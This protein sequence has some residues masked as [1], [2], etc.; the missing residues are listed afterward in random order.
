[1]SYCNP[2]VL[3]SKVHELF[4]IVRCWNRCSVWV[5]CTIRLKFG[6]PLCSSLSICMQI[7]LGDCVAASCA[8]DDALRR[9]CTSRWLNAAWDFQLKVIA[10]CWG[11]LCIDTVPVELPLMRT[12]RSIPID[13]VFEGVRFDVDSVSIFVIHAT[14]SM[15]KCHLRQLFA[16]LS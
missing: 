2:C 9:V 6:L 7:A 5:T 10:R 11:L 1:M 14:R 16:Q 4:F 15:L 8:G 13:E 3:R 12:R